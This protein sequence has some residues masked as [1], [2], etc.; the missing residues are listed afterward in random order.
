MTESS[1]AD[2]QA[3]ADAAIDQL[4]ADQPATEASLALAVLIN[5]AVTRLL[6]LSR[7]QAAAR[8]QQP[9]WPTWAQLHNASRS[10]V[11]QASTCRD[12]AAK[13]AGRRQ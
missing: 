2:F 13:L 6:N 4:M 7:T 1:G 5:R 9:E 8:R 10:L 3:L 12:L 11:L